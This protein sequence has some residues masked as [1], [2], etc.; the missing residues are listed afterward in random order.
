MNNSIMFKGNKQLS[1]I[2]FDDLKIGLYETT[3]EN[4]FYLSDREF[5]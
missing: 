3:R 5:H 2:K 1:L 4:E